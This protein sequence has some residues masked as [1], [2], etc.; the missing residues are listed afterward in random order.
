MTAARWRHYAR[1]FTRLQ[2]FLPVVDPKIVA[3]RGAI[4]SHLFFNPALTG[5][6]VAHL[7]FV[8]L[9]K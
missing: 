8:D 5:N 9:S 1:P 7:S 3:H 2:A 6:A 4:C